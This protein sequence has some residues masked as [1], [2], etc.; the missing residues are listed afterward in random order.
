MANQKRNCG[1]RVLGLD[2]SA[3]KF[4]AGVANPSS[5]EDLRTIKVRSYP[6]TAEGVE[7]CMAWA[8]ASG[9]VDSVVMESTG[10]Y[11]RELAGWFHACRP[12][13]PVFIANP[14][15]I[16]RFGESLGVRTKTDAQDARVIACYGVGRK[17]W[18]PHQ[19]EAAVQELYGLLKDRDALVGMLKSEQVR[20]QSRD[21]T[22]EARAVHDR[23]CSEL[24]TGIKD[25]EKV[26]QKVAQTEEGLKK[27]LDL[28]QSIP[29]V[30]FLT[31]AVIV[32]AIGD[33]RRFERSRQ[34]ASFVGVAPRERL[35]GKSIRGRTVMSKKGSPRVRSALYMAAM[36]A[37]RKESDLQRK[38][39]EIVAKG[40]S[41]KLALGAIMRRILVLMRAIL[42]SG[43]PFDPD[44]SKRAKAPAA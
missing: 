8:A 39:L 35:S 9:E 22:P 29:G 44:W 43:N 28:L 25:L 4:D 13:I 6:R 37:I 17:L 33:L 19:K 21:Q 3:D 42:I 7:Q 27:D 26:I 31:A 30:G 1:Q 36:T 14:F 40:K 12:E 38:F 41:P 18:I 2:V 15:P 20:A 11:S 24:K 5:Y 10:Y 32:G 16:K 34:L 23:I